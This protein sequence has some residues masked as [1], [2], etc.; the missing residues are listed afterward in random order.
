MDGPGRLYVLD[1]LRAGHFAGPVGNCNNTKTIS[2]TNSKNKSQMINLMT[3]Q[4]INLMK[5]PKQKTQIPF[6]FI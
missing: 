4:M 1:S 6:G 5:S 3:S 2:D